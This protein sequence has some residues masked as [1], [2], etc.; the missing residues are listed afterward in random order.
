MIVQDPEQ[1]WMTAAELILTEDIEPFERHAQRVDCRIASDNDTARINSFAVQV[2]RRPL[3]RGEVVYGQ[4]VH[5]VAV[6]LL[7]EGTVAIPSA[8][9][10]LDV[11]DWDPVVV[12]GQ[13]GD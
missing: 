10:G 3:R 2:G 8:Q 5:E 7:G 13:S 4:G 6:H 1:R 12:G 11:P 9:T